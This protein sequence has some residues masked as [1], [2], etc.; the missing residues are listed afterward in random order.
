MFWGTISI[1]FTP[2]TATGH[3]GGGLDLQDNPGGLQRQSQGSLP[4]PECMTVTG[5]PDPCFGIAM[6]CGNAPRSVLRMLD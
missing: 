4:G 6:P 1:G 5:K 2:G 3:C